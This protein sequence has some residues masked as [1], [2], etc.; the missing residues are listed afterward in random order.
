MTC[1]LEIIQIHYSVVVCQQSHE[2]VLDDVSLRYH[3]LS[4]VYYLS[5][6]RVLEMFV[7]V[8]IQVSIIAFCTFDYLF[9]FVGDRRIQ[10]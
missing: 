7:L 6:Y 5:N 10:A 3:S 4:F 9:L 1:R 2:V 8:H